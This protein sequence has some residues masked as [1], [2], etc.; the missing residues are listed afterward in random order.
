M[1]YLTIFG[2]IA[3]VVMISG[4]G[5]QFDKT[6]LAPVTETM[7]KPIYPQAR[8]VV[9][10]GDGLDVRFLYHPEL[11]TQARVGMDGYIFLPMMGAV[12][13]AGKTTREIHSELMAFYTKE[14]KTPD[15]SVSTDQPDAMIFVAGEVRAGGPLP[16]RTYMTVAQALASALPNM[17]DGDIESVVLIR[18]DEHQAD[19]YISYLVNGDFAKGDARNVYLSPGDVVVVPRKGIAMAGDAVRQYIKDVLPFNMNVTYGFV[20]EIHTEDPY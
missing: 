2:W 14:L 13:V 1:R 3:L 7:Q 16:F 11:N 4:C 15:I 17:I 10:A 5:S 20:H 18:K 12:L 8:A 9:A 6:A 19:H